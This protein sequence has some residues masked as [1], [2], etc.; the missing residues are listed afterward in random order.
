MAKHTLFQSHGEPFRLV[1]DQ[2]GGSRGILIDHVAY[3]KLSWDTN[4]DLLLTLRSEA[5]KTAPG[6]ALVL[7]LAIDLLKWLVLGRPVRVDISAPLGVIC[8]YK[9]RVELINL[10]AQDTLAALAEISTERVALH[11]EAILLEIDLLVLV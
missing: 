10:L 9:V 8:L 2:R 11:S 7:I 6:N 3:P 4:P 5:D 1:R